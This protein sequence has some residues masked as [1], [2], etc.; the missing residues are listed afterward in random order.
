L[1][2]PI[3]SFGN[4][5]AEPQRQAQVSQSDPIG[6]AVSNLGKTVGGIAE[7]MQQ[8]VLVKQR[9]QAAL[10][11]AT[12]TEDMHSIHDEIGRSVAEGAVPADRAIPEYKKRV[13]E[14]ISERTQGLTN[15]QRL[16]IDSHLI[17]AS[18]TLERNLNDVAIART[19]SE[20]E[21]NLMSMGEQFQRRAMRDLPGSIEQFNNAV[22]ALGPKTRWD[23][24]KQ[25]TI[26]QTF[27]EGATFNFANATLEGAA[28][29][30]NLELVRAARAKLES[31]EF[32]AIDPH[33]RTMLI[34]KAYAYEN[35][36]LDANA[37]AA[38]K[39]SQE[40]KVRENVA[41]TVYNKYFDQVDSGVFLSMQASN[42]LATATA[43]T[44]LAEKAQELVQSQAKVAGFASLSIPQQKAEL[45]RMTAAGAD[46]NA[47]LNDIELSV[48]RQREKI[49]AAS[50]K[51]AEENP[52]KAAQQ[53]S[54]IKD[55]PIANIAN[56]EDAQRIIAERMKNIDI[57][58]GWAGRKISPLQPEEADT[59]GRL[60]RMLPES[61]RGA[62]IAN[63]SAVLTDPGRVDALAE[64]IDKKDRVL[65]IALSLGKAMTT[66]G[67]YVQELLFRGE[68]AIKDKTVKVDGHDESGWRA[69][70]VKKIGDAYINP[71][72][73][74]RA[75]D[76]AYYIK[77]GL[78]AEKKF[79]DEIS[80]A[81]N[82][83]TGGIGKNHD[84]SSLLL[85]Y[86]MKEEDF[87][88]RVQAIQPADLAK[89]APSG[90]VF[91]GRTSVPLEQ[92]VSQLPSASFIAA[93]K[94]RYIVKAGL[95]Y[96]TIN[97]ESPLIL[98][99]RNAR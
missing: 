48:L 21:A 84:G 2:I 27:A 34:V 73:R 75:I 35:G 80:N 65:G 15:D 47:G 53:R 43:G 55:A 50:I 93:G 61:Q 77:A 49:A 52:W 16:Q 39:V 28:Q 57:V 41:T 54:V 36:I 56:T 91:V 95:G 88:K 42:E 90:Y 64:Q 66:E 79:K 97:G 17:K 37:R 24:A 74:D 68:Q 18:G 94:G 99:T 92:F 5:I 8:A 4:V 89:Q 23:P 85:P 19:Q 25:S 51:A 22:D 71:K 96:V 6:Q 63:I 72:A 32:E 10:T 12:L 9:S 13:G 33:K 59:L 76:A 81:V 26:K 38:A 69:D 83:A 98:E 58:E 30:G 11:A 87:S 20:T 31:P 70:I 14:L 7:D 67:R 82:L 29:T 44:S 46:R 62:A 1:R 45:E 3:G 86:G 40:Q 78:T 60:V